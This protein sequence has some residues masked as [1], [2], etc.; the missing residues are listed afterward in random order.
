MTKNRSATR[1]TKAVSIAAI[2]VI[3]AVT[4]LRRGRRTRPSAHLG[5]Q[6]HGSGGATAFNDRVRSTRRSLS[7][8][9][10]GVVAGGHLA[11]A[12]A[13]TPFVSEER[14]SEMKD[15][16]EL[17][18]AEQVAELLGN[19][20]GAMMKL[21]QMASYIDQGLP[22]P[23]RDALAQLQ[24]DAPPMAPALAIETLEAELG[25]PISAVF[26]EFDPT[27]IAAA[28]I[29][30][31]HRARL[32]DG[33]DVAV[34][35]QYPGIDD[36]IRADLVN[37][38]SLF[39][40]MGMLFSGMDP[41]V[42]IDELKVRLTEELD[43]TLEADNQ[44]LFADWYRGHP[45]IHVPEVISEY[46]TP[47]VLVTEFAHGARW[48]DVVGWQEDERNLAA[49]TIYRYVFGGIYRLHA[50]NGDP[51][52]GNYLFEPGGRV[53]FLDYGLVKRF[54]ASE[55][56]DFEQMIRDMQSGD[57]AKYRA[58]VERIGLL[59]PNAPFSDT[60]VVEYFSHFYTHVA[61]DEL[62]RI[63]PDWSAEALRRF[64]DVGGP[65]G[66]IIKAA[67]LPPSMVIVQRINLGLF[68]LLGE[69][70]AEANW[71]RIA[72]ELWPHTRAA[73][74]TPMGE[75]IAAWETERAAADPTWKPWPGSSLAT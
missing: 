29:G 22:E 3:A 49:E 8:A 27:A 24:Q 12:K 70:H 5:D 63:E 66:Q 48:S 28:S 31:V 56:D 50:F 54:A 64:F 59:K 65:Y 53:T 17:K 35:I 45:T 42:I 39:S 41:K 25:Q 61:N 36:I 72:E 14:A 26:A 69:L 6:S 58:T 75:R 67:N 20:K 44:R 19:M 51:H 23:V 9:K 1:R 38:D 7:V 21:G 43:Y 46:C 40:M 52:P 74:S 30:Q 11:A 10:A 68:A 32:H 33:R 18:S 16:A 71:R 13:A 62:L 73:P 4:A 15:A 34:K 47:K 57:S 2:A 37:V 55:I 60:E